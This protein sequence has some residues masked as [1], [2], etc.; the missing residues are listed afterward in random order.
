MQPHYLTCLILQ[1]FS[2]LE[3]PTH[4]VIILPLIMKVL[5]SKLLA[6][7]FLYSSSV[8]TQRIY[9]AHRIWKDKYIKQQNPNKYGS[10]G[11]TSGWSWERG[12]GNVALPTFLLLLITKHWNK[13]VLDIFLKMTENTQFWDMSSYVGLGVSITAL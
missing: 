2:Q 10:V 3:L 5:I 6:L 8:N 11:L 13:R 9:L 1:H 7:F 12:S 4:L